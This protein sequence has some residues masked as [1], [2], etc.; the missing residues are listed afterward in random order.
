MADRSNKDPDPTPSRPTKKG[1]P[2]REAR[3]AGA[4]RQN[5]RLRKA[6]RDARGANPDG[7]DTG[8]DPDDEST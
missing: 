1:G 7:N 4:L 3:L 2:D 6:Q 5:L 8:A